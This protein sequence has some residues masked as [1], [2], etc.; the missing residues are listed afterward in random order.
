MVNRNKLLADNLMRA[1]NKGETGYFIQ[2]SGSTDL[3]KSMMLEREKAIWS[4]QK[5]ANFLG[6]SSADS[7]FCCLPVNRISGWM[8]VAR[9]LVWNIPIVVHE[10]SSNPFLNYHENCSIVSLTPMQLFDILQNQESKNRL[11]KFRIVLVG[12]G[13]IDIHLEHNLQGL[14]PIFYHT[15]GMTETYSHIAMRRMNL[16]SE[17]TVIPGNEIQLNAD[18]CLCIRNFITDNQWLETK[19]LATIHNQHFK[20]NGRINNVVNSGG[21]K[22]QAEAI[23]KLLSEKLNLPEGSIFYFGKKDER[24][25]QKPALAVNKKRIPHLPDI[26]NLFGEMSYAKPREIVYKNDFVYT[27]T[28]K[29]QRSQTLDMVD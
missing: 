1:W 9:A 11:N 12:G 23:E 21:I 2:T 5:T 26:D 19:D 15:Y 14:G 22:I 25:G 6:I 28:G 10:P 7:I 29:I 24:L 13:D 8:Q 16:E 18:N 3:P 4:C 17:F 27:E 20:I